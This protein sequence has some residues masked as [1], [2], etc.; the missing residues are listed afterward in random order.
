MDKVYGGLLYVLYIFGVSCQSKETFMIKFQGS[1]KLSNDSWAEFVGTIPHLTDF[2]EC[3][4][5]KLEF[6]NKKA[7]AVWNYCTVV[8][9]NS[10][11]DCTQVWYKRDLINAGSSIQL[12]VK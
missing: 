2:T 3:H 5:E 11:M 12:G 4:W 9:E 6:F 1:G 8:S 10:R 7:H